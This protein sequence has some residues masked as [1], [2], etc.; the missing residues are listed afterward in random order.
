M[1]KNDECEELFNEKRERETALAIQVS[2]SV[3]VLIWDCKLT[4]PFTVFNYHTHLQTHYIMQQFSMVGQSCANFTLSWPSCTSSSSPPFFLLQPSCATLKTLAIVELNPT[5]VIC[6]CV[7]ALGTTPPPTASSS[8]ILSSSA[9]VSHNFAEMSA[10][11]DR[12]PPF[13]Q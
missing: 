13:I 9:S 4:N 2:K 11:H 7:T 8:C 6:S 5:P 12:R 1:A 3:T 10:H